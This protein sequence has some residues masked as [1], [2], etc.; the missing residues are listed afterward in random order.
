MLLVRFTLYCF[1]KANYW[2]IYIS[3]MFNF[4]ACTEFGCAAI[5]IICIWSIYN[6]LVLRGYAIL[7]GV[8]VTSLDSITF[9]QVENI[10]VLVVL[11]LTFQPAY[12]ANIFSS[13]L[14]DRNSS[15]GLFLFLLSK[16]N[17]RKLVYA[18][19]W[20]NLY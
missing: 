19:S 9:C 14:V 16:K 15:K 2:H 12:G 13:K 10:N 8:A 5:Q 17:L 6:L 1:Y 11:T 7:L 20:V 3:N 4:L 18:D